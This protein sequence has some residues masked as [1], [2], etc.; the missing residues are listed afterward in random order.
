[1]PNKL[2]QSL[3]MMQAIAVFDTD[4]SVKRPITNFSPRRLVREQAWLILQSM[5]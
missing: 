3:L 2:S 4:V 1:M 5:G